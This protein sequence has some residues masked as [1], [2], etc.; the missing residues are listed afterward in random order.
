MHTQLI[1]VCQLKGQSFLAQG[2]LRAFS[3]LGS[4]PT[5]I[6]PQPW[7]TYETAVADTA[8]VQAKLSLHCLHHHNMHKFWWRTSKTT[9]KKKALAPK[10]WLTAQVCARGSRQKKGPREPARQWS[11]S[12]A[13]DLCAPGPSMPTCIPLTVEAHCIWLVFG[14]CLWPFTDITDTYTHPSCEITVVY[15]QPLALVVL[16]NRDI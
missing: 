13:S 12:S 7:F 2:M 10:H 3:L 14:V 15:K 16:E 6:C 8:L 5:T 4:L 9:K 1:T 11:A